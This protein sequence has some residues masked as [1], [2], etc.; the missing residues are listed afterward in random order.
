MKP[1][2]VGI[3]GTAKNTGKTTTTS[4]L[5]EEIQKN[6]DI[7]L[8]LTSIGYD[9]EDIDNITGLP[10]PKI[11]AWP[12]VIVAI[13]EKC[14]ENSSAKVKTLLR[15]NISTPLG[16]ILI[17]VVKE[18]GKLLLAGP[19]KSKDL[20]QV[21]NIFHQLQVNLT[22]V[23]GALNRIAP[24][25]E[26]DGIILATGAAKNRDI[27]QLIQETQQI[28]DILNFPI[29]NP[30]NPSLVNYVL[31]E[32]GADKVLE[33]FKYHD[34]LYIQGIIGE[35]YFNYFAD[36]YTSSAGKQLLFSDAIKLLLSGEISNVWNI[37]GKLKKLDLKVGVK[38]SVDILAVTVNPYYPL[39]RF[40]TND[41]QACYVDKDR[42]LDEFTNK[43]TIPAYDVVVDGGHKLFRQILSYSK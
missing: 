8:G 40:S 31:D 38:K 12:G 35:K 9:G 21:I 25:V 4:A 29:M 17:A 30:T 26:V 37:L 41:Y 16:K 3:A 15:T 7:T 42:L 43:L 36:H 24:M 39:Y 34:A 1:I 33:A 32:K 14:L 23:D 27:Q 22:L 5:L 6:D 13:S 20:A 28:V 10:K 2:V 19:N 11:E 18:K